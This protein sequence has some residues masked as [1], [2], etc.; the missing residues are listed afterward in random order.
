MLHQISHVSRETTSPRGSRLNALVDPHSH[1]P[2]RPPHTNSP[3][4]GHAPAVT[5]IESWKNREFSTCSRH[6]AWRGCPRVRGYEPTP[7]PRAPG[8]MKGFRGCESF[9]HDRH[10]TPRCRL[11]CSPMGSATSALVMPAARLRD[12]SPT[13]RRSQGSRGAPL[14]TCQ[15][16]VRAFV[17]PFRAAPHSV[18]P[19]RSNT[20]YCAPT[21]ID[22]GSH[23]TAVTVAGGAREAT[24]PLP[25]CPLLRAAGSP[26]QRYMTTRKT[27]CGAARR[28][29]AQ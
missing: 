27:R 15:H 14:L 12:L 21:V 11:R 8:G 5:L 3:P 20:A 22:I 7:A 23:R 18:I 29:L 24:K 25:W 19:P 26:G 2:P 17:Q 4:R 13:D 9:V 6:G 1:E 10:A 28:V 16:N